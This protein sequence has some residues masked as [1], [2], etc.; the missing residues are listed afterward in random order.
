MGF[1]SAL[2]GLKSQTTYKYVAKSLSKFVGILFAPIRLT[3]VACNALGPVKVRLSFSSHNV[4][5][6]PLTPLHKH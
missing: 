4:P 2:K 3:A 6:P 5:P 1:N